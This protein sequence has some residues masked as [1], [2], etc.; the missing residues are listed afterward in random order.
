MGSGWVIAFSEVWRIG[1][2]GGNTALG[3]N[4]S[5]ELGF[6][7][8]IGLGIGFSI[9]LGIG[10]SFGMGFDFCFSLGFAFGT[11]EMGVGSAL[12]S[13]PEIVG[14][15]VIISLSDDER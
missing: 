15:A 3:F 12:I 2:G 5:F 8:G 4:F 11:G 6:G 1:T 7:F 14:S 10:F 13:V 9:G